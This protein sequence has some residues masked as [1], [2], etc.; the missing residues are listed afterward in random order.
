M[1]GLHRSVASRISP[2][3]KRVT[4][5]LAGMVVA[6]S[7]GVARNPAAVRALEE[8]LGVDIRVPEEPDT[9][10]ALGAALIARD[11]S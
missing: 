5:S 9:V 4:P 6:M 3:V 1:R 2:L 7:G 10:G 8:V 11:R